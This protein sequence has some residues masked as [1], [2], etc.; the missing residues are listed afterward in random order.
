MIGIT[1]LGSTGSIGRNVLDIVNQHQDQY[2]V[3]ALAANNQVETLFAQ[4]QQVRPK[5]AVMANAVAAQEL[6]KR[7]RTEKLTTQVLLGEAALTEI[8]NLTEVDYV[9][10]A[11]VGGAGL[12]PTL[13]AARAGKRILLA[14]KEVLVMAGALFI[15]AVADHNATLLPVDSEHN[16]IFQCMPSGY[17]IGTKPEGVSQIILTA[18]GGPFR[19]MP[20]AEFSNVNP[21]QAVQHPNWKMGAKITV[22]CATMMNKGLEVIEAFWLFNMSPQDIQVVVHPQSIIHSLVEY[23]DGSLLAQLGTPDMRTPIA[24]ALAWPRRIPSGVN[25]LDLLTIGQLSFEAVD[26]QRFPCLSLAF[27]ALAAGGTAA[28]LLNGANE[29]A[30]AA[31]LA[32]KIRFTDIGKIISEVLEIIPAQAAESFEVILDADERARQLAETL[33]CR[34]SLSPA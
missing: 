24:H 31:F 6:N 3:I 13:A 7:I 26:L 20:L 2:Q 18:S 34:E 33:L 32:N 11:I 8:V 29:V 15:Q 21:E 17:K 19:T 22:D 10:A 4:C 28:T 25:K 27:A 14:N 9:V 16:A 1:I 30:V 5:F 23:Y 12:L